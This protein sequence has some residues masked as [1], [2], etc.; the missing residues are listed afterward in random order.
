MR[1]RKHFQSGSTVL[2]LAVGW[3]LLKFS[4]PLISPSKVVL[5]LALHVAFSSE[6]VVREFQ[7][8]GSPS[9]NG[10]SSCESSP[11]VR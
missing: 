1:L 9:Q 11:T 5:T 7:S 8:T 6:G 3:A 4:T 10:L 2:R